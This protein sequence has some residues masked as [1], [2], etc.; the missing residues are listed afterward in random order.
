VLFVLLA[1]FKDFVEYYYRASEKY[2][3]IYTIGA[4]ISSFS[5]MLLILLSFSF[6]IYIIV[7]RRQYTWKTNMLALLLGVSLFLII[8]IAIVYALAIGIP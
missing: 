2:R 7:N 5:Q 4:T 3:Y 8:A 6:G 1:L